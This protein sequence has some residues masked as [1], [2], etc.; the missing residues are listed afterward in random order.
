MNTTQIYNG[1]QEHYGS[2][3]KAASG[4]HE[5]KVAAAFGYSAE[6]LAAAPGEA[7]LGLSCG[8]PLIIAKLNEVCQEVPARKS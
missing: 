2:V 4:E 3:A 1:V 6:E 8:N 5:Q 7:N